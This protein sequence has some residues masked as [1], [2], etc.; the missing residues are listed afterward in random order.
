MGETIRQVQVARLQENPDNPRKLFGNLTE[1]SKTLKSGI[2]QPL[3][4]RPLADDKLEVV[5]GHR[6]LRGAK[7]IG[8]K[9]V[10]VI[11]REY[12]RQEA[13]TAMVVENVHREDVNPME[14]ADSFAQM[15]QDFGLSGDAISDRVKM[16]RT[17][18]YDLLSLHEN[19]FE[20][21][22]KMVLGGR[23]DT[24]HA[25]QLARVR[26]ERLQG[27]ALDDAM[28][29]A[30]KE[31]GKPPLRALK[32]LIQ[33]KYLA[34]AKKGLTKRQRDARQ[35]S[36][37][38]SAEAGVRRQ[39]VQRLLV[40]VVELVE[41]RAHLDETDMRMMALAAAESP[42][43]E[44]AVKGVFDR[45]NLKP[46]NLSK[47]G[48]TQ[49]RSLVVELALASFVAL[50][51]DGEHSAGAKTVAKAYGLNLAELEKGV[52]AT[53]KAEALFATK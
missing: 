46:S 30:K 17:Q 18:V 40:R 19:L 22:R 27:A 45:R 15:K 1:F 32:L 51:D 8:L 10:P 43:S 2:L 33:G 21:T 6:R 42:V 38:N 5:I 9:E 26:G 7:L 34:T 44:V 47:V 12:T 25:V 48:A 29:L 39:V 31:G 50:D 35:E 14:L 49:L 16:P 4:A 3:V 52:D 36:T 41:R 28:R 37:K 24:Q 11:V 53:N 23:L 13:L 20:A